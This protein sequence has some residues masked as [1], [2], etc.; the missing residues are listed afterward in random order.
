MNKDKAALGLPITGAIFL[1]IGVVAL[2]MFSVDFSHQPKPQPSS[3]TAAPIVKATMVDQAKVQAQV[4]RIKK[5]EQAQRAAENKRQ[6]ELERQ[7]AEAKR[8][9]KAEQ[10]N[11]KQLEQ[12]KKRQQAE[13]KKAEEAAKQAKLKKDAEEKKAKQAAEQRRKEEQAQKAA[14]QKRKDAEALARK[15]EADRKAKEQAAAAERKRKAEEEA[16]RKAK[17]AARLA[18][19]AELAAQMAAEQTE[20]NQARQQQVLTEVQR[21]SILIRQAIKRNLRSDPNTIGKECQVRLSLAPDGFVFSSK[22]LGG[23]ANLCRATEAAIRAAGNL[24]VSPEA[25]VYEQMKE[26]NLR[27]ALEQ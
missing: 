25:D 6:Q 20:L 4:E 26:I 10:E 19:E 1:H 14:E 8:K 9:N 16:A 17:E 2:L 21:Y 24:P 13:V 3:A 15:Q 12:K 18:A 22:V 5:Q 11:L 27:I 23:D 7:L